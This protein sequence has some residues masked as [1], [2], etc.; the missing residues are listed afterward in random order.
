MTA[1]EI[2][3]LSLREP[4]A[5]SAPAVAADTPLPAVLS[6]LLDSRDGTVSVS[7]GQSTLGSIDLRRALQA[8]S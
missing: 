8:A 5:D 4:A 6:A 7:D 3:Q 1:Q 2:L